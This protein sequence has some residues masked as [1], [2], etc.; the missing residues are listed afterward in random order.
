VQLRDLAREQ[1]AALR[2]EIGDIALGVADLPGD[3]EQLRCRSLVGD[4]GIDLLVII[5]QT[6]ECFGVAAPISLVGAGHQQSEMLLFGVVAGKVGMD[7]PGDLAKERLK[8]RRGIGLFDFM[9]RGEGGIVSL[10]R[11]T[12]GLR[13]ALARGVRVVQIHL[14]FGDAS[15]Q[16]VQLCV[17][18]A[19][20]AEISV[21]KVL[22]LA[23]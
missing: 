16:I 23:A 22:Q 17:E 2:I 18:H 21:F 3:A 13:S 15:L 11:L 10:L 5:Q 14:A 20:L 8:A 9:G 1:G 7:A 12:A 19:N 6:L 4:G